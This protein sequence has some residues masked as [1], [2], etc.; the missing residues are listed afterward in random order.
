MWPVI[1]KVTN[2]FNVGKVPDKPAAVLHEKQ[3][4][5]DCTFQHRRT[6]SMTGD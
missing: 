6:S 1:K 3:V 5:L 4:D 2:S